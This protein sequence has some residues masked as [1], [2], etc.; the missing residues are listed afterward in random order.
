MGSVALEKTSTTYARKL[1]VFAQ[2]KNEI[3]IWN[4]VE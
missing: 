4:K 1:G 3:K 2:W